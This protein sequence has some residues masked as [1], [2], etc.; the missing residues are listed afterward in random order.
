MCCVTFL[1]CLEIVILKSNMSF[2]VMGALE[3]ELW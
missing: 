2:G 1:L 3:R